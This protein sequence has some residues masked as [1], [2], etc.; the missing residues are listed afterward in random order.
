[1]KDEAKMSVA[2]RRGT[3]R[4]CGDYLLSICSSLSRYWEK[5]EQIPA[6]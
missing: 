6:G 2:F 4:C 5:S 1:M 3:V